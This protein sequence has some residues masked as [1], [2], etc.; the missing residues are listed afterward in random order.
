VHKWVI[1]YAAEE[2]EQEPTPACKQGNGIELHSSA[3]E[4]QTPDRDE[5]ASDAPHP[6]RRLT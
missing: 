3:W 4:M 5:K 2:L 6:A 1:G